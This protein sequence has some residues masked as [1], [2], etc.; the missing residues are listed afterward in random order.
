MRINKTKIYRKNKMEKNG[1]NN[2]VIIKKIVEI[3]LFVLI[4]YYI[5]SPYQNCKRVS[6]QEEESIKNC[7][8]NNK[9]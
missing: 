5:V 8:L 6:P 7:I 1:M 2:K 3:G 4:V 9:W